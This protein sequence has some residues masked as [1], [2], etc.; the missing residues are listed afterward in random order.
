MDHA[1]KRWWQWLK[2]HMIVMREECYD[3]LKEILQV[4]IPT[5]THI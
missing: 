3:Q 2:N 4:S 1:Q 5:N